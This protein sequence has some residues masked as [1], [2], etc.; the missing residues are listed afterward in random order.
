MGILREVPS[1]ADAQK[2]H[3]GAQCRDCVYATGAIS[4]RALIVI[5]ARM[6]E[7]AQRSEGMSSENRGF[8][9]ALC[10]LCGEMAQTTII[11]SRRISPPRAAGCELAGVR[12]ASWRSLWWLGQQVGWPE[13]WTQEK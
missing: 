7:E 6:I 3:K 9:C 5:S 8:L 13:G 12:K 1:T 2:R 11:A 10:A 4:R